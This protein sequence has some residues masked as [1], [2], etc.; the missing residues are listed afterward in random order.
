MQPVTMKHV[1]SIVAIVVVLIYVM[2]L[3]KKDLAGMKK[4]MEMMNQ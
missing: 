3:L 4:D 1:A 2:N